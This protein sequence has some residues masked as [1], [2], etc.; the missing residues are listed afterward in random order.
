MNYRE[1]GI[2]FSFLFVFEIV[3]ISNVLNV[4]EETWL[5]TFPDEKV[6]AKQHDCQQV[7]VPMIRWMICE[8]T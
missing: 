8:D 5:P 1:F 2:I 6:L 7:L 3:A 4:L